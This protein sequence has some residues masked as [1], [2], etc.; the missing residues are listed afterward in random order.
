[1]VVV[2]VIKRFIEYRVNRGQDLSP[3]ADSY[4][5]LRRDTL[6][7]RVCTQGVGT[8]CPLL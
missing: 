1:M 3:V 2:M 4:A 6:R 8:W 5:L 7:V